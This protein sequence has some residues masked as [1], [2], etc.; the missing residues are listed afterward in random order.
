MPAVWALE[1]TV[2]ERM[3][4]HFPRSFHRESQ[5][6][7]AV[8]LARNGNGV[9]RNGNGVKSIYLTFQRRSGTETLS[10]CDDL[11]SLWL[12]RPSSGAER[13]QQLLDQRLR[14]FRCDADVAAKG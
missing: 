4:T 12:G 3:R 9:A 13:L 11:L 2:S 10:K 7:L 5:E 1:L 6:R 8:D 14:L